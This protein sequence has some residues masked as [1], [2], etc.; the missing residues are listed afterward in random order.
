[1]RVLN[2]ADFLK[3]PSGTIYAKGVP[4]A[5]D[6]V[7]IKAETLGEDWVCLNPAWIS[8]SDSGEAFNRLETMLRDG[9]SFPGEDAF[10]R[11]G[12]FDPNAVFLVF[13]ADDLKMLQG[14]VG[15]AIELLGGK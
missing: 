3:M 2:R 13:E 11:D 6:G 15:D 4:W 14:H 12:C 9:N 1:M 5:F 10:G 8:A 7:C